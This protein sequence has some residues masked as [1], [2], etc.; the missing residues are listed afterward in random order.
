MAFVSHD[1]VTEFRI[2]GVAMNDTVI[3]LKL[4]VAKSQSCSEGLGVYQ[5]K[6]PEILVFDVLK[7]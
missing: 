5:G 1:V 4:E 6:P 2:L 7:H 3:D